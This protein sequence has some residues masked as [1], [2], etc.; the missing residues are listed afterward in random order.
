MGIG[1]GS[2]G[3]SGERTRL[4]L[5]SRRAT[6]N[7]PRS[8]TRWPPVQTV[9]ARPWTMTRIAIT[10]KAAAGQLLPGWLQFEEVPMKVIV[11]LCLVPIGVGAHLAP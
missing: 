10:D 2:K 4:A 5:R 3:A 6:G 8:G 7:T 11:D 9:T 1:S